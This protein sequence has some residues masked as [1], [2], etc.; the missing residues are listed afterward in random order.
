MS[1]YRK[2]L[3]ETLVSRYYKGF[4]E[5]CKMKV[6]SEIV[7]LKKTGN[8]KEP[9][10]E[11]AVFM[12]VKH[13]LSVCLKECSSKSGLEFIEQY[14]RLKQILKDN[15]TR[16]ILNMSKVKNKKIRVIQEILKINNGIL[17]ILM[18][19]SLNVIMK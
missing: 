4:F 19:K 1:H 16:E 3:G 7:L 18:I 10:I 9:Y 14:K 15:H 2:P 12:H 11:M 6:D 8:F 5:L 17:N 13:I